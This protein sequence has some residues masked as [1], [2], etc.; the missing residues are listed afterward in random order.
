MDII[1]GLILKI[2]RNELEQTKSEELYEK[3]SQL[4][5]ELQNIELEEENKKVHD[6]DHLTGKYRGPAHSICN[7]NYKVPRSIP[8][9]FHNFSGYDAHLLVKEFGSDSNDIKLI[10]KEEKY[11]SFS[12][13]LRYD[14]GQ[15][16]QNGKTI[17]NNVELR[18][19]DSY[20]FLPS[21]L[22]SFAKTLE[23]TQL[24]ELRK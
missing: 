14:S 5:N 6:H 21:S 2:D 3:L 18:F 1:C 9:Y 10:P 11:I 8:I 17:Y 13:V 24:K 23:K 15:K 22:N 16:G 20:K 12:K 7:L 19:L 4:V